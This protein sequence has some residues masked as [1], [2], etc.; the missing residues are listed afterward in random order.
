[1][2]L[3]AEQT[4]SASASFASVRLIPEQLNAT[5]LSA[6]AP[7]PRK[8][9][10]TIYFIVHGTHTRC[11]RWQVPESCSAELQPRGSGVQVAFFL[12]Q[13]VQQLRED[14]GGLVERFL[15]HAASRSVLFAHL[16]LC[17]LKVR[18]EAQTLNPPCSCKQLYTTLQSWCAA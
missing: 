18:P 12:P 17:A 11:W 9:P 15:L 8:S 10:C 2:G 1:M 13:L 14:R 7:E 5:V 6:Y 3:D 16:L 4:N